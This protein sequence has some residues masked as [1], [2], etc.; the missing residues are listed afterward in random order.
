MPVWPARQEWSTYFPFLDVRVP[1]QGYTSNYQVPRQQ[2]NAR[3]IYI[4]YSLVRACKFEPLI[5]AI[6]V[7]LSYSSNFK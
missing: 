1:R 3:S 2:Q 7:I 5:Q 6:Q 4:P